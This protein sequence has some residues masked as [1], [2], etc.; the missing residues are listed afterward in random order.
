MSDRPRDGKGLNPRAATWVPGRP[1]AP[2]RRAGGARR[3]AR[4]PR[5][6]PPDR[7]FP[8]ATPVSLAP[9]GKGEGVASRRVRVAGALAGPWGVRRRGCQCRSTS[10]G[11]FAGSPAH[12]PARLSLSR[13]SRPTRRQHPTPSTQVRVSRAPST[14]TREACRRDASAALRGAERSRAC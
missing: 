2:G 4:G 10:G 3:E 11:Q 13:P 6:V 7:C 14:K 8:V 9:R 1:R 12:R 5:R